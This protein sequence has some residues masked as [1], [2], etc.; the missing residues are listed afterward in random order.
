M[1]GLY[2]NIVLRWESFISKLTPIFTDEI[3]RNNAQ[4]CITGREYYKMFT[5]KNGMY[6]E[7]SKK[8]LLVELIK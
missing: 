7:I 1:K 8:C 6:G 3:T 2:V 4:L 5:E